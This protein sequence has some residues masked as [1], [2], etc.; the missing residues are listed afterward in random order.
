MIEKLWMFNLPDNWFYGLM[1]A[2]AVI[3][4]SLLL[5]LYLRRTLRY[6]HVRLYVIGVVIGLLWE[7]PLHFLGPRYQDNPVYV[8]HM[9]WPFLPITQ[10]LAAAVW[11]GTFFLACL[12]AVCVLLPKP[13]FDR[14]RWSEF[15]VF[16]ICG[17]VLAL[18][19]E[20][21]A[22]SIAWSYVPRV[23]NPVIFDVAGH[24]I[25]ALPGLI[26]LIVSGIFYWITLSQLQNSP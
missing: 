6:V 3:F 25:T 12:L 11:D 23:W 18:L 24:P 9:D 4:P 8:S 19:V 26:W 17:V 7:V 10:P 15:G 2:G 5:G 14:F 16:V 21:L 22:T 20:V 13:H 1:L